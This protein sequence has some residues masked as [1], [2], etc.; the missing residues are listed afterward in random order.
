MAQHPNNAADWHAL[1]VAFEQKHQTSDAINALERYTTLKPKDSG[2][3]IELAG[4]YTQQAQSLQ[5]QAQ[6]AQAAAVEANP[7][8][9]LAPPSTTPLGKVFSSSSGLQSPITN[10]VSRQTVD[11]AQALYQQYSQASSKTEDTYRR[12][13]ALTPSDASAQI[14]LGQAALAANDTKTAIIAFQ[15]FLKLAPSDPEAGNVKRE[16]KALQPTKKK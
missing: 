4:Q 10:V 1:A 11:Q 7:Q 3:L 16:L 14:Q 5:A 6:D 13:A 15:K 12:V 8:A 9:T 2:A